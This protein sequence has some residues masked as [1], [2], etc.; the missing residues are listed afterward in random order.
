MLVFVPRIYF[1]NQ[2]KFMLI[3]IECLTTPLLLTLFYLLCYSERDTAK[4]QVKQHK[5]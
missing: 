4:M 2:I 1:E 3:S 5:K